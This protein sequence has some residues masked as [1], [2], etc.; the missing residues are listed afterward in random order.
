MGVSGA[1]WLLGS[2]RTEVPNEPIDVFVL[3]GEDPDGFPRAESDRSYV[4]PQDHG[5][6]PNHH[7]ETWAFNGYF[8]T[9][10]G[11]QFGFQ[12]GILRVRLVPGNLQRKSAWSTSEIYRGHLAL[13]DI[14]RQ[15][16]HSYERLSRSALGLSGAQIL[17]FRVW[18]GDWAIEMV[19]DDNEDAT[20]R[21]RATEG[22]LQVDLSLISEKPPIRL[23]NG[24]LFTR[25]ASPPFA[26]Y[27]L[28]RLVTEGVLKVGVHSY[29]VQGVSWLDRIWG[30]VPLPTGPSVWN[31]FLLQLEDGSEILVFQLRRRNGRGNPINTGLVIHPDGSTENL[32]RTQVRLKA[33]NHW[34]SSKDGARYPVR[35]QLTIPGKSVELVVKPEVADQEL[36]FSMRYWAGTVR[37]SGTVK[38]QPVSGHGYMELTGYAEEI[39]IF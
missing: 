9:K 36:N 1:F 24:V 19:S 15:R 32:S 39:A 17:P 27:F 8:A 38:G 3:L 26:S 18:V 30:E 21:L 16:F 14:E 20:F 29:A 22:D 6:H 35:W 28:T 37:L 10:T 33:L 7:M 13:T 11:R 5:L 31:R 12:L 34:L 4:F 2:P 25:A 23:H